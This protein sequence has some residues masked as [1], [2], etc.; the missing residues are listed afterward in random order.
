M[1][2][3]TLSNKILLA[4]VGLGVLTLAQGFFSLT[5][6]YATK[7]AV[8]ALNKDTFATLFLAGK[9][10]AV[11]K[12][13]RIAIILHLGASSDAERSKDEALVDKAEND[14]RQ[15]RDDYP[16]FD[17]KDRIELNELAARQATFYQVWTQ[18]RELSRAGKQ[19]EAWSI[20]G[21]KLQ[22]ATLARRKIEEKL[23]EIDQA[24][25]DALTQSALDNVARGIPA[26]WTVLLITVI[27]GSA[28]S[29]SFAYVVRRSI[30]PLLAAIRALGKGV[31]RGKVEILSSDDIG[32][33]S[34]YMNGALE[35]MTGTVSGIDYC[36]DKITVSINE[37]LSH[38]RRAAESAISQRDRIVQIGESMKEMVGSVQNVSDDSNHASVSANN[39]VEIARQGGLIV[40]EALVAM[41][42]IAETVTATAR[43]IEELGKNSDQ[44][45]RIVAVINEIAGQ[46]NLLALNA[47]IEAARAG[48]Q[49]RGFAVVAG[50]VRRLAERTT[51]ATKEVGQMIETVQKVTKQAVEQM[52]AGTTQV[53]AGVATTSKAGASLE[54][55]I[56]AAQNVGNM[57]TRISGTACQQGDA[58]QQINANVEEIAKLTSHSA[59]DAQQ[60]TNSCDH[61][62]KL[63]VSL[64]E[65][66]HQFT[67][68]QII[69]AGSEQ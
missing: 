58:A 18:I 17:P 54:E 8:S 20:Y 60:S 7:R 64:K 40:N 14:L 13:Q 33:M 65:I 46:T 6:M 49:G 5:T 29:F 12:D 42:T 62:S 26:V 53:E 23:A 66:V 61:L 34:A 50:E 31:L 38:A 47:A 28:G 4:G 37:I 36:S 10:K 21:T 39:A 15:I 22:D 63:A 57:I 3:L 24:R 48:D 43:K 59:E 1:P 19:Q 27:F 2:R 51:K 30:E 67:F 55:I 35:Q 9:M 52:K 16:K 56:A 25:G 45:G 69:S 68:H 44:I 32:S 11:A 41:R